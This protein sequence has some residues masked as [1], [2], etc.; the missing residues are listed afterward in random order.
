LSHANAR[1]T[2]YGRLELVR[3]V[4]E[5][6]RPVA[7]V[8]RELNCSRATGH[9]W[10]A[11][12]RREGLAGLVDRSSRAKSLPR[13]TAPELEARI[14]ALRAERKLGRARVAPLV[15]MPASTVHTP[16]SA[17]MGCIGCGGWI[18]RLGS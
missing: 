3:R 6:Q 10:L 15:G 14:L 7:H 11:R 5:Q 9:K 2:V 16:C 18:A 17:G 1:L 8:V 13:K 12:W 4:V